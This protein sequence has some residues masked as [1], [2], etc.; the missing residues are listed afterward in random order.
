MCHPE[1]PGR[2]EPASRVGISAGP[3]L[4]RGKRV[5]VGRCRDRLHPETGAP[6][7]S[8]PRC[9]S[10]LTLVT[11][12]VGPNTED[13]FNLDFREP[14]GGEEL[15]Q[16]WQEGQETRNCF[17]AI[18]WLSGQDIVYIWKSGLCIWDWP[19]SLPG[20]VRLTFTFRLCRA[21]WKDYQHIWNETKWHEIKW[22]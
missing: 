12:Q 5:A 4:R 7:N 14:Q 20:M 11:S 8:C 1:G 16:G 3:G 18:R 10:G 2:L 9:L 6:L 13:L 17:W 19:V 21:R 15:C 22:N